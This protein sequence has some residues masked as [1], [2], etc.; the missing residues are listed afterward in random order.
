MFSLFAKQKT[1][2]QKQKKPS[3]VTGAFLSYKVLV[4]FFYFIECANRI[5]NV[6]IFLHENHHLHAIG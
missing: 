5:K 3:K 2:K 4:K 6:K 1:K